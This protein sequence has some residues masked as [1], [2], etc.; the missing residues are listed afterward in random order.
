VQTSTVTVAGLTVPAATVEVNSQV[1]TADDTGSFE[2]QVALEPGQ[3][4][5]VVEAIGADGERTRDFLTLVYLPPPPPEFFLL[6]EEP[7][8]GIIVVNQIV[9]VAG[10]TIPQATVTVNGVGV[11]V[12]AQGEF[13]T[14]VQLQPLSNTIEVTARDPDG[15]AITATRRVI[16]SP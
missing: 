14:L 3:N 1:V 6:V 9:R 12:N 2:A 15:R 5:I 13:E 4:V 10:R 16:Y 11:G 7:T 8:N